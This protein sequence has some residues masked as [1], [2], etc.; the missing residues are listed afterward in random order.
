MSTFIGGWLIQT[1][2]MLHKKYKM[3]SLHQLASNI[4]NRFD[5]HCI[6][7]QL[8][9]EKK[10]LPTLSKDVTCLMHIVDSHL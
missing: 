4:V 5:F 6:H 8:C 2:N 10:L 9:K 3:N 1:S 7:K